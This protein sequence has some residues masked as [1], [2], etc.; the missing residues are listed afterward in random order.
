MAGTHHVH[1]LEVKVKGGPRRVRRWD[2]STKTAAALGAVVLGALLADVNQSPFG[3]VMTPSQLAFGARPAGSVTTLP[4]TLQ[5]PGT[6]PIELTGRLTF[7]DPSF[8][9]DTGTCGTGLLAGGGTCV[10]NI[11]FEP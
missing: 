7:S 10:V 3:L 11:L 2:R 4:L 5:N 9:M 8:A 6:T 1:S